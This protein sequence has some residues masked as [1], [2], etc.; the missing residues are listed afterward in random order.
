M[1][2]YCI[3]AQLGV[4]YPVEATAA[5]SSAMRVPVSTSRPPAMSPGQQGLDTDDDSHMIVPLND[6]AGYDDSFDDFSDGDVVEGPSHYENL[7]TVNDGA[8]RGNKR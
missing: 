5:Y 6:P 2:C 4:E 7:D 1:F 3:P 8:T